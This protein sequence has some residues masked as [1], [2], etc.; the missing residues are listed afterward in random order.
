[1][2]RGRKLGCRGLMLGYGLLAIL[3]LSSWDYRGKARS[4][5]GCSHRCPIGLCVHLN[6]SLWIDT[7]RAGVERSCRS[8]EPGG[9]SFRKERITSQTSTTR[10][11]LSQPNSMTSF[12]GELWPKLFDISKL[13]SL[14][15]HLLLVSKPSLSSQTPSV[16]EASYNI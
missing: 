6:A 1:M 15:L 8:L 12:S 14:Q 16:C 7:A 3:L 10:C 4:S 2:L 13:F 9:C 11:W 5:H